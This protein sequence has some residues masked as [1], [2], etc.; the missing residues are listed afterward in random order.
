MF[1][2][3]PLAG[4]GCVAFG[5][6]SGSC[7]AQQE[8]PRNDELWLEKHPGGAVKVQHAGAGYFVK[9]QGCVNI[10]TDAM[11]AMLVFHYRVSKMVNGQWQEM[12]K[13]VSTIPNVNDTIFVEGGINKRRLYFGFEGLES[14]FVTSLGMTESEGGVHVPADGWWKDGYN[15]QTLNRKLEWWLEAKYTT[16]MNQIPG[17]TRIVHAQGSETGHYDH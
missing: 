9:A 2:T 8:E 10:H 6:A 12:K 4:L 17:E 15:P 13:G 1:R 11:G 16:Y 14:I 5:F 3:Q 7:P